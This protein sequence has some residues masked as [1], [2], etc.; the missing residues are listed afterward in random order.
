MRNAITAKNNTNIQSLRDANYEAVVEI[1]AYN[2]DNDTQDI[3]INIKTINGAV[4]DQVVYMYL[5]NKDGAKY[6]RHATTQE[7]GVKV[8]AFAPIS[9]K[10]TVI[11]NNTTNDTPVE[12]WA[13][14]NADG[15]LNVRIDNSGTST[16]NNDS[17]LVVKFANLSFAID[18]ILNE[19]GE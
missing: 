17:V 10:G 9:T 15:D 4:Y 3:N 11:V 2:G 13:I 7:D 6:L 1:P 8:K 19:T 5:V 16:E 14:P 12:L 18:F